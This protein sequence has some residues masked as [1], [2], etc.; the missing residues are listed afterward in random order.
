M[1]CTSE[2]TGEV[3]PICKATLYL[4]KTYGE[5][6]KPSRQFYQCREH[7]EQTNQQQAQEGTAK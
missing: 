2:R 1:S 3:C 6:R 4:T 7:G 5:G